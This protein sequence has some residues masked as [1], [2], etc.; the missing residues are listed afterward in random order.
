MTGYQMDAVCLL[1]SRLEI[2]I[3][4]RLKGAFYALT[5]NRDES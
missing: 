5:T 3:L 4:K 1:A 2:Q